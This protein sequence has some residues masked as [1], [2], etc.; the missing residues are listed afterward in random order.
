MPYS[1]NVGNERRV[2]SVMPADTP[3][4]TTVNNFPDLL[5]SPSG[6]SDDSNWNGSMP[7]GTSVNGSTVAKKRKKTKGW[8]GEVVDPD[9][10][11]D[12]VMVPLE[13]VSV[14]S[15][16]YRQRAHEWEDT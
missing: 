11:P 14:L 5:R 4:I 6:D 2:L 9:A 13:G 16:S 7:N 10:D 3:T 15:V 12:N 8:A 1:P